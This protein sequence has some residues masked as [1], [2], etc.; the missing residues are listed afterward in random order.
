VKK[1]FTII[2]VL[3]S[4]SLIGIIV[5]QLSWLTNM[6]Q[7]SE[8]RIKQQVDEA[9]NSAAQELTQLK[10]SYIPLPVSEGSNN[11]L[12]SFSRKF[13]RNQTLASKVS[14]KEV[15]EII[16]KNFN[17][18]GLKKMQFEFAMI[19]PSAR[20][21]FNEILMATNN[22]SV[23]QSD[24]INN[25][26]PQSAYIV[27]QPGSASE[28]LMTNEF[29]M[30]VALDWKAL[31]IRSL[32]WPI[33]M[34]IVFTLIIIAA[35]YVTVRTMLQQK[36]IG[37][38]KNDFINNMTHEFKTPLA[39]ISLAVDALKNEKVLQNP[40]KMDYFRTI[41]KE[42]NLR[43]NK[44]VETILKASQLEKQEV[45]L[46]L[47]PL[48]VH[49][50]IQDVVDNFA[51]QLEDKNGKAEVSLEATNDLIDADEVH[52]SNLI[53]NLVDNAVKYSKTNVPIHIKISSLNAG[54]KLVLRFE[55]NGIGMSKETV[56]RVF[57]RFYRAH[58]GN[59]HNV[60]G[61]GLGL[62]YVK[63]MI[64]AHHGEIKVESTLGKGSIFTIELPLKK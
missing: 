50:I 11:F 32:R 17:A 22:F 33:I 9:K 24:S 23:A 49:D 51:L 18:K 63:S 16:R 14:L 47:S 52:F 31:V 58:T 21:Y 55:D 34:S 42:E 37:E 6:N 43:M 57:E 25:Y 41:I 59:L 13:I 7:L 36:K 29:L 45:D 39:T 44:Q 53:N 28:S 26:L 46:A 62:S 19:S 5:L 56:K 54:K 40:E 3:I 35:F 64:E 61:F 38:I 27:A 20:D 48:H 60:K 4:L 12:E 8:E 30:I 10:S 2:I 1:T 15:N